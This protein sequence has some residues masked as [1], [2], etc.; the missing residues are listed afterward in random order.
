MQVTERSFTRGLASPDPG[1][2]GCL[3]ALNQ[4]GL[5][6]ARVAAG[7]PDDGASAALETLRGLGVVVLP[8]GLDDL[9]AAA[10]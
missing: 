1:E 2:G 9:V 4:L 6:L 10:G 3:R 7:T 5:S 8:H